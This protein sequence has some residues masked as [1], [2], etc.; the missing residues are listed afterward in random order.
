MEGLIMLLGQDRGRDEHDDLFLIHDGTVGRSNSNLCLTIANIST[1]QAV[2]GLRIA[3]ISH[4]L[5]NR[6][7]LI[8]GLLILKRGLKLLIKLIQRGKAMS[9]EDLSCRVEVNDLFDHLCHSR[10]HSFL[11]PLPGRTP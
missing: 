11:C 7:G 8:R 5:S 1:D 4:D 3:H 2:H 9:L 6:L 10:L